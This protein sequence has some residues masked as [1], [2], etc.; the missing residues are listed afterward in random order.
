MIISKARLK[1]NMRKSGTTFLDWSLGP[2]A[3]SKCLSCYK[4]IQDGE[5]VHVN[6]EHYIHQECVKTEIAKDKK[7]DEVIGYT[8][9]ALRV[10]KQEANISGIIKCTKCGGELYY[11]V[12]SN[13]HIWAQCLSGC[14]LGWME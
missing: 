5:L 1:L 10:I 12:H 6:G 14:G 7:A 4:S 13:G 2:A 3:G 8:C 11:E 9:E